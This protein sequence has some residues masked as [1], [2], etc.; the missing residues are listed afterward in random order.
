MDLTKLS[1]ADL[2]ALHKGD[3]Q[4]ISDEGLSV[5]S[6]PAT[7]P[8]MSDENALM[9]AVRGFSQRGKEAAVGLAELTGLVPESVSQN[10]RAEREWVKQ[11]PMAQIGSTAADIAM[12]APVALTNP[13]L[14]S[15]VS[16]GALLGAGYGYE[17]GRAHV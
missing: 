3:L 6:S 8:Q 15:T 12:T 7:K 5:L 10:V 14:A 13:A 17:I 16:G 11:R 4:S 9:Q 2:L 1:D